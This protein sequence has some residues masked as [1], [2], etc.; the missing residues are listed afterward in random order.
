[1]SIWQKLKEI[2]IAF[3]PRQM[4]ASIFIVSNGVIME[5]DLDSRTYIRWSDIIEINAYKIDS[6]TVD[7][8]CMNIV[9]AQG[10]TH[11]VS[12][13]T[14]GFKQFTSSLLAQYPTIDPDWQPKVIFPPF[15]ENFMVL[16]KSE[17]S[18]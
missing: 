15:E 9:T 2:K 3:S 7:T 18:A 6:I 12:E 16:F 14:A 5:W 17:R 10:Q 13:D 11:I 1:L 4:A 8:L